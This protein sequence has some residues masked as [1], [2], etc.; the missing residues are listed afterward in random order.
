MAGGIQSCRGLPGENVSRTP[1]V[2]TQCFEKGA[3]GC[4]CLLGLHFTM[5]VKVIHG[6]FRLREMAGG[7]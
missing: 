7:M 6:T 2:V 5:L 3:A 4:S 1:I